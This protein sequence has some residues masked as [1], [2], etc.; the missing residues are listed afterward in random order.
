MKNNESNAGCTI[1]VMEQG[2]YIIKGEVPFT[3][4]IIAVDSLGESWDYKQGLE[5]KMEPTATSLCRCGAS[6]KKPYCDGS[7]T[8]AAWDPTLTDTMKPILSE[9]KLIE[10]EE[11]TLADNEKYCVYARFCHPGGGAWRLTEQSQNPDARKLAIRE[12]MM[13]PSARLMSWSNDDKKINEFDFDQSLAILE[14]PEVDSSAGLW[15]KGGI[16]IKKESGESFETRNRVVLCRC[17][18]SH[19]KPYCDGTHAQLRWNDDLWR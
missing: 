19:N 12:S 16:E 13:C 9:A 5:L 10:G 6:H 8:T 15:V 14:D 3:Q 11:L 4:Q 18:A 1:T 7:H 2:P 17:G